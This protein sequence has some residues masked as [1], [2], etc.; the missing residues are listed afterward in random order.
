[1]AKE[2]LIEDIPVIKGLMLKVLGTDDYADLS[3]L[4]GLT[5]HTYKATL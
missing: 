5:N 1:M 4:G 2:V 3:R